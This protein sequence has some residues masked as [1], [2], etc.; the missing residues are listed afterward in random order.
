MARYLHSLRDAMQDFSHPL[1][2]HPGPIPCMP[3][4]SHRASLPLLQRRAACTHTTLSRLYGAYRCSHCGRVPRCG[5][6]YRC[7]QDYEGKLPSW[8]A[9]VTTASG[10]KEPCTAGTDGQKHKL[11]LVRGD[12]GSP[13][14]SPEESENE[15]ETENAPELKPWMNVAIARGAYTD[16][17]VELLRA[18]RQRVL[19]AIQEAELARQVDHSD[20][21]RRALLEV[22]SNSAPNL[23]LLK[24]RKKRGSSGSMRSNVPL[25]TFPDCQY[26][27]CSTCR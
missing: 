14:R 5:W 22:A 16:E 12:S 25:K 6:V 15:A 20:T 13:D 9:R 26:R 24:G 21:D 11:K 1:S 7:T 10:L 17:Q 23:R 3:A 27:T 4:P 19:D 18:Q 8:E 2:Q